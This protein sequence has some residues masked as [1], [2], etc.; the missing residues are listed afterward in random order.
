MTSRITELDRPYMFV[1]EQVRGPFARFHHVHR[2]EP[3][4]DGTLRIDEVEFDA[5]FGPLGVLLER[6]VLGR[7]LER[8]IEQRNR[9]LVAVTEHE[10]GDIG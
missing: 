10:H 6:V 4:R 3:A 1:D 9:H 5:P 7:Y 8:L 2:F